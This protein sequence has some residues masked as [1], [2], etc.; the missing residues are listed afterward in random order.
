LCHVPAVI[1]EQFFAVEWGLTDVPNLALAVAAAVGAVPAIVPAADVLQTIESLL[2]QG[3][4]LVEA[5][6]QKA[7]AL[8]LVL[9]A[10]L[11]LP[12]VA[13]V[14][15]TVQR[16]ARRKVSHAALRAAQRRAEADSDWSRE[17]A[18]GGAIPA[19]PSQA[20]ITVE[21]RRNGTVPL[22]GQTIRIGRHEDNDICLTDSSVHRYHAVIQRTQE[23]FVIMDVTGKEGNGV[24]LNGARTAQAQL[25][26]GDLI[27]LGRA[28]L[29][30]ENAPV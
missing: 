10:L 1:L 5:G 21:G 24:K 14:S 20:W 26:D 9:S 19:W 7:P 23:G 29:K 27:E 2:L 3:I 15:F 11:V 8:M 4:A 17:G 18:S 25:E 30:F 12:V 16:S 22:A 28:K 6:Y 13:L